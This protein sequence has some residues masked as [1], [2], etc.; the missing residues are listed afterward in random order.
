MLLLL[1]QSGKNIDLFLKSMSRLFEI[2]Y[3]FPLQTS[4]CSR[5]DLFQAV[6]RVFCRHL[7]VTLWTAAGRSP[8]TGGGYSLTCSRYTNEDV[9]C[10][11]A[12]VMFSAFCI[13]FP[14]R[15]SGR[16]VR[17][18]REDQL[19]QCYTYILHFY[20]YYPACRLRSSVAAVSRG[21]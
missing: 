11:D 12:S 4:L 6:F 17:M 19:G 18:D 2:K 13:S 14:S 16:G 20:G 15:D 8:G 21:S 3:R 10:T 7:V 9:R 5:R 1:N